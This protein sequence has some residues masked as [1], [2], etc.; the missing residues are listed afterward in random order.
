MDFS[1]DAIDVSSWLVLPPKRNDRSHTP[2][3]L[4]GGVAVSVGSFVGPEVVA[5]TMDELFSS[6]GKFMSELPVVTL[7]VIAAAADDDV[8]VV[9]GWLEI[10]V[11]SEWF[12]DRKRIK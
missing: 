11:R 12:L 7:I 2:V 10:L 3:G 4:L 6:D 1:A 9:L 8:V 5:V